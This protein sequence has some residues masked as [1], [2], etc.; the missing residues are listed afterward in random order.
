M[1]L[2]DV[3]VSIFWFMLL[4]AWFWLLIT[5][6]G[7]IFRDHSLGGWAKGLW[8]LFII[9]IPWLGALM[10]IVVR[11]P[12]MRERDRAESERR[13][14]AARHVGGPSRADELSKLS[15]LR[16][17]GILSEQEFR[18]AKARVLGGEQPPPAPTRAD[19]H[20]HDGVR[21]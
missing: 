9:V 14:A 13:G 8:T 7:D 17:N 20:T 12:S 16:D 3:L 11:G 19:P 10:Y 2:W 4:L 6:L 5:L 21:A 1:S 15:D 18:H